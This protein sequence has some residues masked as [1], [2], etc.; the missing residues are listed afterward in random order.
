[1]KIKIK[2]GHWWFKMPFTKWSAGVVL[3]P[4]M[5]FKG[6][7]SQVPDYLFRH[8]LQHVYQ[9]QRDGFFK[10]YFKY[11]WY[12]LRHG[13]LDNPY[14]VEAF[15]VQHDPLT[16]EEQVLVNEAIADFYKR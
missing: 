11:L 14:E 10:F 2:F 16:D 3:Y 12:L 6:E 5:L 15:A 8:E 7:P 4:W 13:Y 9:I 1:M